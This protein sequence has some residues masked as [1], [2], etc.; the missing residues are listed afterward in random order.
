MTARRRSLREAVGVFGRDV[1]YALRSLAGAKG[2]TIT[3]VLTLALG[4]G[5]NA[6]IFTL[7]RGVLL[8]PLVNRDENRLIY[9]RQSAQGV[10]MENAMFS[11]PEMQDLR[12]RIKSL[13][14]IGDFS[15]IGFTMNG[16]GEPREVRAGVVGGNYFDVMGLHPV[17]GRLLDMRDDGP[18][19]A[20]AVVL[21]YR[22]WTHRAAQRPDRCSEKSSG[23]NRSDRVQRPS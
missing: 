15:E 5:A 9:I 10:G 17:L 21:T 8:R 23:W 19:A 1:K 16:L 14:A 20:G 12:Q 22:F 18:A 2:L 4:I 11:V 7:V 6:A 3:V 13:S